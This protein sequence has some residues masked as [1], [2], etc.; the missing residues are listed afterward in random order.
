MTHGSLFSGIGG[1]ELGAKWAGIETL[2]SCEIEDFQRKIL[3]K[4]FPNV[5][6]YKDIK[7]LE[8]P[9]YV[10]IISGGFPCQDISIAN[11]GKAKGIKGQ[12]S[13]LWSEYFRIIR[14][15]RPKYIIAENSSAITFRGLEQV[16]CDLYEIGYNAEW[17]C[18][19]A[20][21]FGF[22]DI[23]ERIYIIAYPGSQGEFRQGMG[24]AFIDVQQYKNEKIGR[25][26][27]NSFGV[28]TKE[29]V[30]NFNGGGNPRQNINAEPLLCGSVNGVSNWMDKRNGALGNSI[31]PQ[32]AQYL[33]ECIKLHDKINELL[34]LYTHRIK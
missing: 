11:A 5:K 12:R 16:L 6:Q 32:I 9:E 22:K 4:N 2:W 8:N 14:H 24:N 15:V 21:S 26:I 33:F 30:F 13:G 7:E 20:T 1:F 31:K 28:D 18:L 25:E 19:S 34:R 17:Q 27:W 3:K 10:D 29:M 23:R